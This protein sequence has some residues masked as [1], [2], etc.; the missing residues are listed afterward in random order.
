MANL[1]RRVLMMTDFYDPKTFIFAEDLNR[2]AKEAQ[3]LEEL[4]ADC[5]A[6]SDFYRIDDIFIAEWP[7]GSRTVCTEL[8]L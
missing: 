5:I 1:F 4:V 2:W 3:E 7:D 8:R 6:A